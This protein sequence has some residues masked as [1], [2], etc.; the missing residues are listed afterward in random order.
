MA[1]TTSERRNSEIPLVFGNDTIESVQSN[2]NSWFVSASHMLPMH[3]SSSVSFSRS[4]IDSNYLGYSFNGTIDTLNA[5]A[6]IQP[7]QKLSLSVSMGYTDNLAGSLYQSIIPGSS[8]ASQGSPAAQAQTSGTAAQQQQ[9]GGVFQQTEQSSNALYFS[10]FGAYALAPNLQLNFQAQRRE[11]TFLGTTYGANTYGAGVV[12]T[13][14]LLGGS[15]NAAVNFADNT[16]DNSIGNAL[17]FTTNVGYNR[18]FADWTVSGDVQLCA[19]RADLPADLHELVLHLLGERA[20]PLRADRL[21]GECGRVAQRDRQPA[22]HRQRRPKL[23]DQPG[24][25]ADYPGRQLCQDKWLRIVKWKR[26]H[27]AAQSAAGSDTA[28]MAAAV[29]WLRLFVFGGNYAGTP[30]VAVSQL[31]AGRQQHRQWFDILR[32]SQRAG[33][34]QRELPVQEAH[35]HRR[36]RTAGAGLQCLRRAGE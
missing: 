10:G 28:G 21:D 15:I 24:S 29:R 30:L 35:L 4:Y 8:S 26:N 33:F 13:R 5:A 3:G 2:N 12:Y 1:A 19:E 17:S 18:T 16:T 20:A 36:I 11:Q 27:S 23:F 22:E 6:G 34:H 7:T 31:L 32:Q 9:T 25:A 14:P